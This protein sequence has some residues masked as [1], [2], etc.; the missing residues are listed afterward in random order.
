MF[1]HRIVIHD[2]A[3]TVA[4]NSGVGDRDDRAGQDE[5]GDFFGFRDDLMEAIRSGLGC[6]IGERLLMTIQIQ[7]DSGIEFVGCVGWRERGCV[8]VGWVVWG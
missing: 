5:A 7:S 4:G 1:G 2:V 6:G 3:K 8:G